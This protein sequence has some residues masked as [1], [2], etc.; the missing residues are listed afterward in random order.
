MVG[1]GLKQAKGNCLNFVGERNKMEIHVEGA[2][3][4][5]ICKRCGAKFWVIRNFGGGIRRLDGE[6]PAL[7]Y[8]GSRQLEVY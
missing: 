2:R 3:F 4:E 6:N 5:V 1:R 7:C 8:C